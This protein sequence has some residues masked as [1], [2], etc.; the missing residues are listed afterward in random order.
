MRD[1]K[2]YLHFVKNSSILFLNMN[3]GFI[4]LDNLISVLNFILNVQLNKSTTMNF[5]NNKFIILFLSISLP[6][7]FI[8]CTHL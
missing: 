3:T 4:Y 2:C 5:S 7:G 8:Q 6:F 1:S